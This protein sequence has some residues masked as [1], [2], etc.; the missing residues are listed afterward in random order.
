M[1]NTK[2]VYPIV[3]SHVL[4]NKPNIHKKN[5]FKKF[6]L[7]NDQTSL[8]ILLWKLYNLNCTD[9]LSLIDY[10]WFKSSKWCT[11]TCFNIVVNIATKMYPIFPTWKREKLERLVLSVFLFFHRWR[12]YSFCYFINKL[13]CFV[14]NIV[15]NNSNIDIAFWS[16]T[17][18]GINA[19][20]II[21]VITTSCR[22][23]KSLN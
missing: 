1:N 6:S 21:N 19:V 11:C 10:K 14:V 15:T 9:W 12:C 18:V 7:L 23:R 3:S 2:I 13:N 4:D 8:I 20:S 17:I 22:R 16:F 5:Y